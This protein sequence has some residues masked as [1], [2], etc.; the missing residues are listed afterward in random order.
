MNHSFGFAGLPRMRL[1]IYLSLLSLI[2]GL[3]ALLNLC[4]PDAPPPTP[5]ITPAEILGGGELAH[6]TSHL[7]MR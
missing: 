3:G 5:P 6:Q 2:S 7:E 4:I 1:M